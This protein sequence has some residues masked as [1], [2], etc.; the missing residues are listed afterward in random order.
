MRRVLVTICLAT[1]GV[2][3][4][5]GQ[6]RADFAGTWTMDEDRSGSASD[7]T[8]VSP[9]VWDIRQTSEEIVLERRRGTDVNRFTYTLLADRPVPGDRAI[10]SPTVDA[11]GHRGY[12]DGDRLVL[13]THQTIQGKTV[14]AR[15]ALTLNSAGEMVVERVV[16]VEHGYTMKGAQNFSSVKDVFT[17]R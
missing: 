9:V 4:T 5:L 16:E 11:P 10:A 1:F 7:V 17:R 14:T 15:E 6:A 3:P 2:V 12:W 13:E 8:F